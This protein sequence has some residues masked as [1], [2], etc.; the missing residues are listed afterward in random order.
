MNNPTAVAVFGSSQTKPNTPEWEAAE[1]VGHR[2]GSTGIAVVTGGYSGT[3]EAVSKGAAE[4]GGHVIGVTAPALFPKRAG[5][6]PFVTEE[7][8]ASSLTERIGTMMR[9][10]AGA[11]A[12]PGSIGTAT[13]LLVAWNLNYIHR[14]HD[15]DGETPTVAVGP[16]WRKVV[17]VL[18]DAVGAASQDV[19]VVD[20][21]QEAVDWILS[22]LDIRGAETPAL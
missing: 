21:P 12:L 19:H 15:T 9:L 5:A 1:A 22:Q 2:L 18:V 3:M 7:I 4:A 8:P 11:I 6:N 20:D 16:G 13:E 17:A 10:A 14:R